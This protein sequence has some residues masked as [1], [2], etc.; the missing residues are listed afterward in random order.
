MEK[1]MLCIATDLKDVRWLQY[2]L[3][4]FSRINMAEFPIRVRSLE[5]GGKKK[6]NIIYYNRECLYDICIPNRS[7]VHQWERVQWLSK[8]IFIIE[9][10]L[11]NDWEGSCNYDIFWNAFVFLSRLEEYESEKEERKIHSYSRNHPRIE[12]STFDVPVV[13]H[14]FDELERFIKQQ[15]PA[16]PFGDRQKPVIELSHDVDYV[17]KTIQLRLK[18]TAFNSFNALKAI[19]S[20]TKCIC[21]AKQTL[22]F[23]FSNPSY[24]CFDYWEAI[25]KKHNV[26]S[27][28]YVYANTGNKSLK[29]WLL[30]P[31][32]DVATNGRL[33]KTL[34][35]L[36][37]YG[38]EIG[39]HG[40]F[41]SAT[42]YVK[43]SEEKTVLE[44]VIGT[45]VD[46]VRQHW[47]RYEERTTPYIHNKLF[48]YDST[49]GWNDC[50]GFRSGISGRYR[51]YDHKNQ[52]PF[53]Y[54]I[55]PQVIMD[56]NIYDYG[57]D[58]VKCLKEKAL[59]ILKCLRQFKSAHISIS[60]HQR[61]CSSDYG[62]H[63]LYKKILDL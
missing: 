42:D 29:S 20:P 8:G 57:A 44:E 18:Q 62:W 28:F 39:L 10:T 7:H 13:N 49:L 14:L 16:L 56:S 63:T 22:A 23:L 59:K 40:S 58:R 52:K 47:L 6:E 30:D 32:Y 41:C 11:V 43:L 2:I 33:K 45:K 36:I 35:R 24:W 51:P 48:K 38:F 50:M 25:E 46:K 9:D 60:W 1:C 21:L 53:D 5:Q 55:T 19:A 26:R 27:V 12:K 37:A 15:F 31:S 34:G 17:D 3:E 54:M 4:E 61:V